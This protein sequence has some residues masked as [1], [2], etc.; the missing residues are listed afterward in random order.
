[1]E[2]IP[3]SS[4]SLFLEGS[5][6]N[7]AKMAE[8]VKLLTSFAS[9]CYF[10]KNY[11]KIVLLIKQNVDETVIAMKE[12]LSLEEREITSNVEKAVG[13]RGRALNTNIA[14]L[15]TIF[16]SSRYKTESEINREQLL[17]LGQTADPTKAK[18]G[19]GQGAATFND[20][21]SAV[22]SKL[23]TVKGAIAEKM[24]SE[25]ELDRNGYMNIS[26]RIDNI[27]NVYLD[28]LRTKINEVTIFGPALNEYFDKCFGN[29]VEGDGSI[30][31]AFSEDAAESV[32]AFP[33]AI[34]KSIDEVRGSKL[35]V[36]SDVFDLVSGSNVSGMSVM[37]SLPDIPFEAIA[38]KP[39]KVGRPKKAAA[40][41]IE[42]T[43]FDGMVEGLPKAGGG[44]NK[45]ELAAFTEA[46]IREE[47]ARIK[48]ETRQ[49]IIQARL[50]KQ[51]ELRQTEALESEEAESKPKA[52]T[53]KRSETKQPG[54]GGSTHRKQSRYKG[55][56]NQTKNHKNKRRT[57][58]IHNHKKSKKSIRN[59]N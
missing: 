11:V 10:I 25:L 57:R 8:Y 33:K 59:R 52:A 34:E 38:R 17:E 26:D 15:I 23:I 16:K 12:V 21:L 18:R 29:K 44:P 43:V 6:Y 41:V 55:G 22:Y 19:Q 37:E 39:K 51:E 49:K 35:S 31:I 28:K 13:W 54:R 1:L 47:E 53:K 9:S 42:G 5:D 50:K 56:H 7:Y 24:S 27:R 40:K 30:A 2:S 32:G 58:K 45:R 48:E 14:A 20:K 3:Q 46:K 4:D 36:S